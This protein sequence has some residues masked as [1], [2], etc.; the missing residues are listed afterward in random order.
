MQMQELIVKRRETTGKQVAKRLR[1]SGAVP[2]RDRAHLSAGDPLLELH[3]E[4]VR[5]VSR[6]LPSSSFAVLGL[7]LVDSGAE[8]GLPRS[9]DVVPTQECQRS[10]HDPDSLHEG[11]LFRRGLRLG[12]SFGSFPNSRELGAKAFTQA[13]FFRQ[14]GLAG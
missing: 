4:R 12:G 11:L 10:G 13:S 3:E 5:A 2:L 7:R 6:R 9:G 1:R 8:R 14:G